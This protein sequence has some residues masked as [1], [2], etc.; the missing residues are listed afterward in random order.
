MRRKLS[1]VGIAVSALLLLTH[2]VAAQWTIEEST[3]VDIF[4]DRPKAT[5]AS[6]LSKEGA[7]VWEYGCIHLGRRFVETLE[8]Y[9]LKANQECCGTFRSGDIRYRFDHEPLQR[10]R[11]NLGGSWMAPHTPQTMKPFLDGLRRYHTLVVHVET[12]EAGM[13]MNQFDLADT[14]AILDEIGCPVK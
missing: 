9:P 5:V 8:L 12:T 3:E 1:I 4:T 6:L 13:L 11:W 10:R 2:H 14:T 7:L